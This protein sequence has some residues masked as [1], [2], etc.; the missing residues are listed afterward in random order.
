MYKDIYNTISNF[1]K[2]VEEETYLCSFCNNWNGKRGPKRRLSI[3]TVIALNILKYF[4]HVKDLK[5]FHRIIKAINLI[6]EIPNYE[7]FLKASNKALPI[8][9]LFLNA[10]LAQNRKMNKTGIHFI[11]STPVSTSLNR[12][13]FSHK[14][15]KDF[16]SRGKSTKGW[17]Y[18]LKFHGVCS[19]SGLLESVFFTSGNVND[20]TVVEKVTKNMSGKFYVEPFTFQKSIE[21]IG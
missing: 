9:T 16:A 5:A 1:V 12:R 14:V 4:I 2:E 3:T 21:L 13:I 20:S 6:P 17:F 18:G 7:N 11:D 15:T 10:L 8:M 19:E